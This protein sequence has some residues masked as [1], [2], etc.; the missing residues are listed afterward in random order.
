MINGGEIEEDNKENEEDENTGSNKDD[1]DKPIID[2]RRVNDQQNDAQSDEQHDFEGEKNYLLNIISTI[3]N[4]ESNP[5]ILKVG[6]A[7]PPHDY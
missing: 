3:F 1:E 2:S 4:T 6:Q 5:N 7:T